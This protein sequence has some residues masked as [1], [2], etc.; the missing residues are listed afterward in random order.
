MRKKDRKELPGHLQGTDM[1][2][3]RVVKFFTWY[4]GLCFVSF[5]ILPLFDGFDVLVKVFYW[6]GF[7]IMIMFTIFE[8]FV[9]IH[10]EKFLGLIDKVANRR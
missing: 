9:D 2:V 5:I 1:W 6:S 7:F 4:G 10:G 8:L 3:S